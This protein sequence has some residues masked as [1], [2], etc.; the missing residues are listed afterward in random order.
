[1]GRTQRYLPA[2]L[3]FT[4]IVAIGLPACQIGHLVVPC[5]TNSYHDKDGNLTGDKQ[6][7]DGEWA[8]VTINGAAI[9]AAGYALPAAPFK[10]IK[11]LRS[12]RLMFKTTSVGWTDDCREID[13]SSGTALAY[14]Q[15]TENNQTS[16][17]TYPGRFSDERKKKFVTLGA[18]AYQL[19]STLAG[20]PP[21][22]MTA[23]ATIVIFDGFDDDPSN[24]VSTTFTLVFKR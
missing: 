14:Y 16:D 21:N 9:P 18:G 3:G 13:H 7:I 22:T 6:A 10:P 19:K 12:G 15:L 17:K 23:V 24:D 5:G 4:A 11:Y 1:M 8:L 20:T 2:L